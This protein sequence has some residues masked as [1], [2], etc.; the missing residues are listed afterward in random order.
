[1]ILPAA[2]RLAGISTMEAA[3]AFL[4]AFVQTYNARFA[5]PPARDRDLHRPMAGINDL[6]DILCWRE[7]RSVSRRVVVNY[8]RM[9]FMLRPD[10]TSAAVAGKL[11]DIYDFPD[12]RLEIRL[13]RTALAL[14]CLRPVVARQPRGHHREQASRRG[15]GLDQAVAAP[16][17]DVELQ[18]STAELGHAVS[19][20]G[21][22]PRYPKDRM[23]V[24]IRCHIIHFM[25]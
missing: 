23:L 8:N 14:L 17:L 20:G 21:I 11:V 2:G 24:G 9:K 13:E 6:D 7:Q 16:N 15:A 18:Q 19:G 25:S 22:F 1:M 5:K 3:N 12:G 10:K 4:P